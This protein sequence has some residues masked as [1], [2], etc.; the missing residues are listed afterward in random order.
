MTFLEAIAREEGFY[1]DGSRPQRNNNPGD[2]VYAPESIHFGATGSDGRFAIFPTVEMG[3]DA[4]RRWLSVPARFDPAGDLVGGYLGATVRQAINRFA[5]PFENNTSQYVLNVCAWA[6]VDP[7]AIL[8]E[9][10]LKGA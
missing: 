4:L 3:W 1:Q 9:E 8:T 10:M 5:P 2:L 6:E 7:N